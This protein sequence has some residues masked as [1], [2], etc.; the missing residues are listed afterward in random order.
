V[1][2]SKSILLRLEPLEKR[3][4]ALE[5]LL[6]NARLTTVEAMLYGGK[7]SKDDKGFLQLV[8]ERLDALERDVQSL[9]QR[10]AAP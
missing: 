9:K 1:E 2:D 10:G 8:R 5:A 3:V 6:L 4:W 7:I